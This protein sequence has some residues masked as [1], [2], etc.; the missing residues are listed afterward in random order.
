MGTA[1]AFH[2][3]EE[4]QMRKSAIRGVWAAAAV[5]ALLG[6]YVFAQSPVS[7][8]ARVSAAQDL[9]SAEGEL[10][11]VDTRVGTLD[12]KTSAG[13]TMTFRYNAQTRVSGANKSVPELASMTG[14]MVTVQYRKDGT[15]NVA[16]SV[17]IRSAR[18]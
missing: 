17:I 11:Q 8:F 16:T 7:P 15:E 10:M 6:G 4:L 18:R 9:E 1:V 13:A 5:L 14:A 2:R 12:V 3:M